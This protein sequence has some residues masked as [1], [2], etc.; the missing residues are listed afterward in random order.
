MTER[1]PTA[2]ERLVLSRERLRVALQSAAAVRAGP[3]GAGESHGA[4]LD[5]LKAIPG[6]GSLVEAACQW[7]DR[8]PLHSVGTALVVVAKSALQ[9]IAQRHPLGLVLSAALL[10]AV[11]VWSRPWHA[12]IRPALWA[13]LLPSILAGAAAKSSLQ[14]WLAAL[15]TAGPPAGRAGAP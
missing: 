9:P 8:H 5:G 1:L 15:A 4:W 12:I 10:G 11:L 14:S 2:I 6:L 13:G 3:G 7:W